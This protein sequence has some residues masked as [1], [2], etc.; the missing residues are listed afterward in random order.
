MVSSL[1]CSGVSRAVAVEMSVPSCHDLVLAADAPVDEV[2]QLIVAVAQELVHDDLGRRA[3]GR[4]GHRVGIGERDAADRALP[5]ALAAGAPVGRLAD[6]VLL[7]EGAQVVARRAARLPQ[8]LG[9]RARRLRPVLAEDV[10]DPHAQ[11]VR[12]RSQRAGVED[13]VLVVTLLGAG[14]GVRRLAVSRSLP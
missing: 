3:A 14:C 13:A 11:R 5:P 8:P 2:E 4:S 12:Q 7:G 10:V 6:E 1:L 9:E